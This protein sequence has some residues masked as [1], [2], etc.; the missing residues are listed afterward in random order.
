MDK[1][2]YGEP[3]LTKHGVFQDITQDRSHHGTGSENKESEGEG[4]GSENKEAG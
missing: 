4:T 3:V 2:I 1:R